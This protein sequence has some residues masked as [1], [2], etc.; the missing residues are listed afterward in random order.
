MNYSL[1]DDTW[2][3]EELDAIQRVVESNRF[4]MGQEVNEFEELFAK[5]FKTKYAVMVNSGSSANLLAISALCYSGRL[6]KGDEVIVPSVSWSTTYSPLYQHG[7]SLN[8]VDIDIDTL[9]I[10]INQ[11]EKAI[12]PK[13]KALFAVNLLGNP[14]CFD[15]LLDFCNKFNLILIEDNCEAMGAKYNNKYTGTFGLLGT[16]SMFYSHH[17]CTMEGGV[18]V[19]EDEELYHYM[20][21]IRAHGWTRNLPHDSLLYKKDFDAFYES[22]NFIVPGY[23]LRPL[24]MEAAIGK[25][26]LKK[27]PAILENRR[28]NAKVMQSTINSSEILLQHEIGQS[29]WFGFSMISKGENPKFTELRKAL[30]DHGVECRPIVAGNFCRNKV[31][32]YFDYHISGE[33]RNSNIIHDFGLFIGNHASLIA[34]EVFSEIMNIIDSVF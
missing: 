4:T 19:T 7:L 16:F 8:F 5:F 13:T 17:I 12:T 32:D 24:E 2:T 3:E 27:L 1:S 21:A 25:V 18:V 28:A 23:N 14:N 15:E 6:Q 10:D 30:I 11:L 33:L 26:Q 9:N 20:L 34:E 31:I 29:S 22:F